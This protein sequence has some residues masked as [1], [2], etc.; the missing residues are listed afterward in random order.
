MGVVRWLH[1]A[2]GIFAI[3]DSNG[4][5]GAAGNPSAPRNAPLLNPAEHLDKIYMHSELD[6]MEVSHGPA[7]VTVSHDAVAAA[8]GPGGEVGV[9]GITFYGTSVTDHVL[10]AHGLGYVPDFF[11]IYEGDIV[12]PGQPIQVVA[13]DGRQRR[14]TAYATS[15]YILLR[16]WHVRTSAT[17]PAVTRTYTVVVFKQPP[18]KS[19]KLLW[20]W[21]P[22]SGVLQAAFGK[23]RSDRRYLQVVAGGSPFGFSKGTTIDLNNGAPRYVDPDG[24]ITDPIPSS[25]CI[26]LQMQ[27]EPADAPFGAPLTYGGAFAG[28]PSVLVQVP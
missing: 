17:I 21:D 27:L 16:E 10:L 12:Y 13:D 15:S 6:L 3:Y 14:V 9:N 20:W 26:R 22:I 18:A 2:L 8:S 4:T 7:N 19:G 1:P 28:S 24:S 25:V 11:V 23:F 5:S